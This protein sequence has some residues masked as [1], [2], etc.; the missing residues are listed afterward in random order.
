MATTRVSASARRQCV[1]EWQ[2]HF[3]FGLIAAARTADGVSPK[4][5]H[6]AVELG[7]MGKAGRDGDIDDREMQ[8]ALRIGYKDFKGGSVK[9]FTECE[10]HHNAS[11]MHRAILSAIGAACLGLVGSDGALWP[12]AGG[13]SRV[14]AGEA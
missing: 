12:L 3:C 4:R 14:A 10:L 6:H 1:A 7:H 8:A 5:R 13:M 11:L 9:I 2:D